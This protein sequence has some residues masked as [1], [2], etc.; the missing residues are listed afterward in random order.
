MYYFICIINVI[1]VGILFGLING[2]IFLLM[3]DRFCILYNLCI[4]YDWFL[5]GFND[6]DLFKV[7]V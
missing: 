5:V 3:I 4:L 2:L 7:L 1:L 6:K